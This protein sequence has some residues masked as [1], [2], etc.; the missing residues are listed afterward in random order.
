M[1]TT[2][3]QS[4]TEVEIIRHQTLIPVIEVQVRASAHAE[5]DHDFRWELIQLKTSGGKRSEKI[6]RLSNSSCEYRNAFL[7]TIRQIIREDVRQ[8]STKHVLPKQSS[9]SG[10]VS[11][12]SASAA[13]DDK[14]DDALASQTVAC[15]LCGKDVSIG[16]RNKDHS[17]TSSNASESP[18][19][20]RRQD[21]NSSSR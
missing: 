6:Y 3:S 14:E 17:M 13:V 7:R 11:S 15:G 19:W 20:K 4:R 21:S 5:S 8:M 9:S 12:S 18:I 1:T 16:C 10:G 2:T